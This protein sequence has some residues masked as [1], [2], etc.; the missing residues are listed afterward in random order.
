MGQLVKN[1][2]SS[3]QLVENVGFVS[4]TSPGLAGPQQP[5][6]LPVGPKGFC[7]GGVPSGSLLT[8]KLANEVPGL[9]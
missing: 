2:D 7:L 8:F 5:P 3:G 6:R 4:L 1:K 9:R